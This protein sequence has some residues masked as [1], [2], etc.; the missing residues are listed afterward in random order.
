M[1][2]WRLRVLFCS[3]LVTLLPLLQGCG[4]S[5]GVAEFQLYSQAFNLQYE[6]GD[7]FLDRLAVAER[8]L[9]LYR[10]KRRGAGK[11]LPSDAAYYVESAD[12]PLTA[13]IRDS[14]KSLKAYNDALSALGNGET[15]A[16]LSNRISTLAGNLVGAAAAIHVA[17]VNP[18]GGKATEVMVSNMTEAVNIAGPIITAVATRAARESFRD[19]LIQ[20]YPSMQA[21][22]QAMR[23]GSTAMYYVIYVSRTLGTSTGSQELQKD[24]EA[25]A[26]WVVLMDKTLIAM[27]FAYNS[28]KSQNFNSESAGLLETSIEL[29]G[30]AEQIKRARAK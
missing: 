7:T 12:P 13:S 1:S 17:T 21:L 14:L 26:G 28:A 10:A 22:L 4:S 3:L 8:K 9:G 19:Q 23:E 2:I 15:A 24:R 27:R 16:A 18:V 20:T 30:L 5:K 29:K 25:L 6:Q 11:F